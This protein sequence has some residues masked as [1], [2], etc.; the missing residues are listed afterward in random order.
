MLHMH[1]DA[2]AQT[3]AQLRAR[4]L[5]ATVDLDGDALPATTP[6]HFANIDGDDVDVQA[7]LASSVDGG[8]VIHVGHYAFTPADA[9]ALSN[10]LRE[11]LLILGDANSESEEDVDVVDHSDPTQDDVQWD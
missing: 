1:D 4:M 5:T 2:A 6:R 11:L 10:H 3:V 8:P 7:I 9:S